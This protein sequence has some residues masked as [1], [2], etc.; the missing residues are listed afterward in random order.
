MKSRPVEI[1]LLQ[2]LGRLLNQPGNEL[3]EVGDNDLSNNVFDQYDILIFILVCYFRKTKCRFTSEIFVWL[4]L[5]CFKTSN[6]LKFDSHEDQKERYVL[7][8]RVA[9]LY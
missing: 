3:H 1:R 9:L 2:F 4:R 5:P 6:K 7:A 8:V